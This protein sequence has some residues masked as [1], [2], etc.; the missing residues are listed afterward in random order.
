MIQPYFEAQIKE[1]LIN[2]L[3]TGD[4][5]TMKAETFPIIYHYGII[6]K[7]N[8][9]LF[10]YHNQTDFYNGFGGSI[11]R[12]P[13]MDYIRGREIVHV[14]PTGLSKENID[15]IVDE[16]KDKRYHFINNN[17]EHFANKLKNN[18]FISLQV[19]NIAVTGLLI[20]GLIYTLK[21]DR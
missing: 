2:E 4:L 16:L 9:E 11:V 7:E 15:G 13:F 5:L 3:E 17:C 18:K 14:E 12:Q 1:R 6:E 19:S 10:I 20:F 8:N 21:K